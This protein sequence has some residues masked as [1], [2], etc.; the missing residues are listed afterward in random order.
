MHADQRKKMS[1]PSSGMNI[2]H[3]ISQRKEDAADVMGDR[4]GNRPI[5]ASWKDPVHIFAVQPS[6][7]AYRQLS[8]G[9]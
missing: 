6:I 1:R 9:D 5:G 3:Q 4:L 7:V 8:Q 2:D